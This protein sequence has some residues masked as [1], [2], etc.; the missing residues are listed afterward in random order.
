[1]FFSGF[2]NNDLRVISLPE[3]FISEIL[4][5]LENIAELKVILYAFW[6]L[7]KMEGAWNGLRREDFS[8]DENFMHG[9]AKDERRAQ[10]TLDSALRDCV[11][12]AILLDVNVEQDGEVRAYYFLN[13]E[14]G[15]AAREAILRGQWRPEHIPTGVPLSVEKPNI[16]RL[17]EE[18]VGALTPL[19][20]DMLR[21]AEREYPDG[22]IED[23]MRIAVAKNVRNWRYIEAI[24]RRWKEKG[25]DRPEQDDERE[26]RKYVEGKYAEFIDH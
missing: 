4:P 23:A 5:H 10:D 21:D 18:N 14:K 8:C 26:R 3:Q 9:L 19:V 17:Y 11:S 22:W 2:P 24:L 12:H 25:R 13:S 1:M 7:G 16:F 20:A 15:R 6:R